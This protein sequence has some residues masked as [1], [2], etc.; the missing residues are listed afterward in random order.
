MIT[1]NN[2]LLINMATKSNLNVVLDIYNSNVNFLKA[3]LG[4]SEIS[5]D[6]L[7]NEWQEMKSNGFTT[8][9]IIEKSTKEIIGFCDFKIG[10]TVYLSLLMLENSMKGTGNGMAAYLLLE[11]YFEKQECRNVRIDVVYSYMG[12]AMNFWLRQGFSIKEN[13][14]LDWC[15]YKSPAYKMIKIIL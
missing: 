5:K 7:K 10:E 2:I 9:L 15:G 6:W 1:E 12:N 14:Q 13:I 11:Q 3:H 4:I 8:A